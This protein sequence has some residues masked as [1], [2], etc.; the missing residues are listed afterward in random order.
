M[1]TESAV[2]IIEITV[3]SALLDTC[4]SVISGTI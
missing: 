2:L 3:V 4:F 1:V